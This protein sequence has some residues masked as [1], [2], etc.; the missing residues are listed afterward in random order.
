MYAAS[1]N[2]E[3]QDAEEDLYPPKKDKKANKPQTDAAV[4]T[5]STRI[6]KIQETAEAQHKEGEQK[7][8]PRRRR[9]KAPEQT[10][11]LQLIRGDQ[12]Q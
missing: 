12:A 9:R 10:T 2:E 5:G 11:P 4:Q 3:E 8:A 1:Y 7:D 6:V